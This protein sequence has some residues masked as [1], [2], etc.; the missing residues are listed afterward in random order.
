MLV[1]K[2]VVKDSQA[3]YCKTL[4]VVGSVL[5]TAAD[6]QS[7]VSKVSS[8]L[9][10]DSRTE[11][12]ELNGS[13]DTSGASL[14]G[15][16]IIYPARNNP[17]LQWTL[18]AVMAAGMV[19]VIMFVVLAIVNR[20]RRPASSPRRRRQ[21]QEVSPRTDF[22]SMMKLYPEKDE[23]EPNDNNSLASF[24]EVWQSRSG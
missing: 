22:A 23:E 1:S 21:Q 20:R 2:D 17:G 13:R 5:S 6:S 24:S 15:S 4:G 14:Q 10:T 3:V 19:A 11:I 12:C 16:S 9:S 7:I 18:I 8:T